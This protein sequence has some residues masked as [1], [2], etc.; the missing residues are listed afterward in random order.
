MRQHRR[1]ENSF[2]CLRSTTSNCY[3]QLFQNSSL[4]FL[5]VCA[6]AIHSS[7]TNSRTDS[8]S[9]SILYTSRNLFILENVNCHHSLWDPKG[10]SYPRGQEVFDWVISSDLLPLN[11]PDIP[12]LPRRFSGSRYS[13]D[14]F[15]A[16]EYS[17]LSL[18][19]AAALFT[20]LTLN[21]AKSSIP[22]GRIKRH[23]KAWWF[24]EVEEA[25]NER[26][27]TSSLST[28]VFLSIPAYVTPFS[29]QWI[30]TKLTSSPTSPYSTPASVSI[31]LQLFLGSPLTAFLFSSKHVSSLKAKFFP[32]LKALLCISAS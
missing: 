29:S 3:A 5:S 25:V 16:E 20:S 14:I 24:A 19:S 4:S 23:P 30:P 10:S 26:C 31:P 21:G 11:N 13:P 7:R 28:G 15:F 1:S 22:F 2:A 8:F 18:S 27:K 6:P 9:P 12:T 17:S 32:R